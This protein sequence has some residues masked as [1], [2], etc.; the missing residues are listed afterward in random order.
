MGTL[1]QVVPGTGPLT[2]TQLT[3]EINTELAELYKRS[4]AKVGT[5]AGTNTYT[6]SIPLSRTLA[7]NNL[8]LFLVPNTNTSSCTFNGK[9]LKDSTGAALQ[10]G[11][12]QAGQLI[13]FEREAATDDYR[14]LSP[15]AGGT[16]P[17]VRVYTAASTT[18]TKPAGLRYV[19]VT[20]QAPGGNGT[21]ASGGTPGSG[22]AAGGHSTKV[23][24]A[25]SLGSTETVTIP[26]VGSGNNASFGSHISAPG[27]GNGSG[28]APA[29]PTG[30]DINIAGQRGKVPDTNTVGI[31]GDGGSS[32]LGFG[33]RGTASG[34]G[35]AGTGY[36]SGGGGGGPPSS[37]GGAGAG[38]VVIVEEFY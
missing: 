25:G 18:W 1:D 21:N 7:D 15:L 17:I 30:G 9:A 32:P 4:A 27:G 36:G 16:V 31:G 22:G 11:Q 35:T 6:G 19:K 8:F 24:A 23:I 33:G 13:L 26:A 20:V 12:L 2:A 3:D 10:A 34:A 28:S 14:I 29:A 38:G 37:S 5:P